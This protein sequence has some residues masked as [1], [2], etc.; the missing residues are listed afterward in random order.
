MQSDEIQCSHSLQVNNLERAIRQRQKKRMPFDQLQKKLN[1]LVQ[2]STRQ[3]QS[4]AAQ[5]GDINIQSD[6]PIYHKVSQIRQLLEH[7]QVLV[8]AGETGCGKTTQLPK[9]CLQAG[10]GIRGQIAHT[11]PRRVAATSVA[12]R[13]AEEVGEP[14]GGKVGYSVRFNNKLS[15]LT[16]IKLMTDGI[17]LSEIESD[18]LLSRYEVVIIDEAHERSLN[19]D[20]LL[21]FLKQVLSKRKDL[22]LIITSAT[23]DPQQFS[24]YFNNAPVLTV[25]GRS[26]PVEVRYRELASDAVQTTQ[27]PLLAAVEGA[28]DECLSQSA[29]DI[30]IF[31]DGEGQIKSVVK[32]LQNQ[33][34]PNTKVLPLYARLG[35][36]Q[37]Q[38][39]FKPLSQ[40]KIIISTNVAETSLTVPGIVFVIDIGTARI[41]R[42]SHRNKI[43]QLPV[44]KVSRA[45]ADQRKGRCGRISAGICIR[46]YSEQDFEQ[47]EE[48]TC[49]EIQRTNLSAV[50]LRLLSL[51][52]DKV[53]NFP[54]MQM[55]DEK[56]WKVAFNSLFELGAI[57]DQ[58][59]ISPIGKLMAR[60]P[61]DPQLARILVDPQ[62]A[63]TDEMLIICSL[64]SVREVRERP[65]EK[66]Q[67]ADAC[68][69]V[70][71]QEHS[72]VLTAVNLWRKLAEQR[73]STSSNGFKQWCSKNFINFLGWLEWRKVYTQLKQAV[74]ELGIKVNTTPAKDD[75]VHQSLIS[76]F[77]THIINKTNEPHYLGVRAMKVWLHPS[78]LA[79]K[80]KKNWL[81][82]AEMIETEK[83]YA[84]MNAQIQPQWIESFASHLLKDHYTQV[85]WRKKNGQVMAYL[86][87]TLYGLP[88]VNQRLV[89]YAKV[90]PEKCREIFLIDALARDQLNETFPFILANRK[91]LSELA[92][93]EQKQRLNNIRIDEQ[94]LADLYA[95]QLPEHI[96]SSSALKKWLIKDKVKRNQQLSFNLD[97]LTRQTAGEAEAYPAFI[98]VKGVELKLAYTFAPGEP[99]DGLSVEIPENMIAQF[100]DRD[101]DWLVPGY[102]EEKILATIKSLPK[103]IRRDLIPLAETAHNCYQSLLEG[104]RSGKLFVAELARVLQRESG[105]Q[106]RATDFDMT[107]VP[108]HL[109]AKYRI[110]RAAGKVEQ[111]RNLS[112]ARTIAISIEPT[113][114]GNN[115]FYRD[116]Q[117][118]DFEVEKLEIEKLDKQQQRT[119][120][121]FQGLADCGSKVSINQF[122][123]FD[124]AWESHVRGVARL[125]LLQSEGQLKQFMRGWPEKKQLEHLSIRFRGFSGLFDDLALLWACSL[126]K[127]GLNQSGGN[128]TL[129]KRLLAKFRAD[130]RQQLS[131]WLNTILPL[132][133]Q[134]EALYA[135]I[136][137]LSSR[138][139]PESIND[140]KSQLE[141]LWSSERLQNAS[142]SLFVDYSRYQQGV[143]LRLK[144][145][146]AN[147]PKEQQ[148]M[149]VWNEWQRWWLE[150]RE[151]S[152]KKTAR[153]QTNLQLDKLFWSLQEFRLSLFSPGARIKG[154]ISAKKLQKL[155]ESVESPED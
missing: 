89:S 98:R 114:S 155:F 120:R 85:H 86:D 112:D 40:R 61:V 50:A 128:E 117:F 142:E 37:Q 118:G 29:G 132:I 9:I 38:Q 131:D 110:V 1:A 72:D 23:I 125:L 151:N 62:L 104:D 77:I 138:A 97:Q 69:R 31:A 111:L 6:L 153:P 80:Q 32:H 137:T 113:G 84:R 22:K 55:P 18:P 4:I 107:K 101:F 139:Y 154:S 149:E 76:G 105:K 7:N 51:G 133:R 119:S 130:Y 5:I 81:V 124:L 21:G 42:F 15:E 28:V 70:Y 123:T 3:T 121:I 67:K 48:F 41:S 8:I 103:A 60:L 12:R 83:L 53:E 100:N 109:I 91:I 145:I 13:I 108:P 147:Y 59:K 14:I 26:Y 52:V 79:F 19:I 46:L 44:E 140:L 11:Q 75:Q 106:V 2:R 102:L 71:H 150:L 17:L 73:L 146:L 64:M 141:Q 136:A 78:S 92:E 90:D 95:Q 36:S 93:Q 94:N 56:A 35:I 96:C 65:H 16:R 39:I 43:Q 66:Q 45:S 10:L 134:R 25:E 122:A 152:V 30:L 49:A 68:H 47:R 144:R 115:V 99:E 127:E 87:R 88:V 20:F 135:K 33:K 143:E 116:W 54:F 63:A 58:R 34:Y 129:F 27:E 82:S 74:E 24:R 126:V 57:D 148:A